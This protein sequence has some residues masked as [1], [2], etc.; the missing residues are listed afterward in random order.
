VL[1]VIILFTF[2][3]PQFSTMF[4][5]M[6]LPLPTQ[7]MMAISH[8]LTTYWLYTI[9]GIIIVVAVLLATFQQPRPRHAL[10]H[11]KLRLPIAGKLLRT[12]YTARFARTLSSLYV[13]GIPMIQSLRIARTTIGNAYREGHFDDVISALANGRTLSQSLSIVDGFDKKLNSTIL[14]GEESGRL[15]QML[16]SV[17]DQF[18]YE[19]EMATQRLISFMEPVMII[20]MAVIVGFV[21]ISVLLPIFGM[22]QSIGSQA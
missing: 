7:V 9:G 18:D 3:M 10:D 1:V 15:E 20:I 19:S 4:E 14:I 22:Y 2:V 13:S 17:A 16:D 11:T 5:G 8:F 21:I 12:I 6:T